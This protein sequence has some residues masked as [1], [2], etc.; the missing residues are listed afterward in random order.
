MRLLLLLM[1]CVYD[2]LCYIALSALTKGVFTVAVYAMCV[3]YDV[4]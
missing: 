2:L 3:Y 4:I 1:A